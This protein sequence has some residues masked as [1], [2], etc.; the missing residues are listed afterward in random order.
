MRSLLIASAAAIVGTSTIAGA[1]SPASVAPSTIESDVHVFVVEEN[2][3]VTEDDETTLR[4][5]TA[6]GVDDIAQRYVWFDKNTTHVEILGAYTIDS[7]GVKHSVA[8]GQIVDVQEPHAAGATAF[9]DARLKAVIFPGVD[10]G[11]RIHLKFHKTQ[12]VPIVAGQFSYFV[13]ANRGP[14]ESQ[15]LIFDLPASRK[16]YADARGYVARAP[17]TASGRTRYEFDYSKEH[18][19]RIEDGAVGYA[20]YGDRLMVSTFPDYAAFAKSY[21]TGAIDPTS[22]SPAIRNLALSLTQNDPDPYAKAERLYDWVRRNIRYVYLFLGQSPAAPHRAV[23]IL[24]NRYGDC[25]DHVALYGALLA[26]VGIRSEAALISLGPVHTLPAVPG[27]GGSAINHAITWLPDLNTY[28]DTT[29]SNIEFG[30]LPLAD[31]D[32]P[33]LLVDEGTLSRT[34]PTEPLARTTRLQ[35]DVGAG[36]SATFAYWV[37]DAGWSAEI[38]R[39]NMRLATAQRRDQIAADRL[40]LTSLRGTATLTAGDVDTA[41]GSFTTMLRGTLDDVIWPTGTTALPALTSLSGGIATQVHHWLAERTRTQ[42]YVCTGGE[43]N[44]T[45]QIALPDTVHAIDVPDDVEVSDRF[46]DFR[47]RYVFDPA[48]NVIQVT[49]HLSAKFD[50]QVCSPGDFAAA[51]PTL[52][53]IER[54]V[55]SQVI[56]KANRV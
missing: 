21:R 10:T 6:A 36:G 8:P 50:A 17:T 16:L 3:S 48:T 25:K 51:R 49:R 23:D 40:R 56:V 41:G 27:Y 2:G 12:S 43:F 30:Y 55:Q 33:T 15:R 32:R 19:D 9:E 44:E 20:S 34:P 47:S 45:S 31:L 54:D 42:P 1:A 18:Y 28:A 53:K 29:P 46:F 26:A 52:L 13:E 22:D 7:N 39:T 11:S 14:V 4:A 37:E 24:A 35:V 38:E 5:N